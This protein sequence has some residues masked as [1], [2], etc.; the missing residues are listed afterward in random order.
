[1]REARERLRGGAPLAAIGHDGVGELLDDVAHGGHLELDRLLERRRDGSLDVG[2][3]TVRLVVR[4]RD[5][6]IRI[7]PADEELDEIEVIVGSPP[8]QTRSPSTFARVALAPARASRERIAPIC[9]RRSASAPRSP[10]TSIGKQRARRA[11]R[12]ARRPSRGH[13]RARRARRLALLPARPRRSWPPPAPPPRRS[14]GRPARSATPLTAPRV[15]SDGALLRAGS[16]QRDGRP[17]PS[18]TS[19]EPR[20]PIAPHLDPSRR[21]DLATPRAPEERGPAAKANTKR[22]KATHENT[23]RMIRSHQPHAR[24]ITNA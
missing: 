2:G 14:P 11:R 7:V 22:P 17:I 6:A 8:A 10:S 13:A 20:R 5:A 12:A 18:G 4:R 1:M 16:N 23:K 19:L 3:V 15:C 24:E 9:R 21:G